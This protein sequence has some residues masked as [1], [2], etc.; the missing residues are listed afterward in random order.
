MKTNYIGKQADS[1]VILSMGETVIMASVCSARQDDY[2][3]GF[4][5][6]T[7]DYREKAYAAGRFPGGFLKREG[8]PSD[9]ERL[10]CRA[11]DRG[12]RP[13]FADGFSR[14]VQVIV[15]VCFSQQFIFNIL[16]Y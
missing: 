14:E 6:L 15:T 13:L 2:T 8:R 1:T 11:I 10:V 9:K 5:P 7:V 16:V 3:R 12:I 4:F